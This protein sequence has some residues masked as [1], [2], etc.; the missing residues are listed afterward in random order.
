MKSYQDMI[1][2]KQLQ[3]KKLVE[4]L[5]SLQDKVTDIVGAINK[6]DGGLEILHELLNNGTDNNNTS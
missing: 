4:E 2:D 5:R 1:A 3:R 6:I